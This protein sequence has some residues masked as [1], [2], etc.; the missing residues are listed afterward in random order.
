[1]GMG[2]GIWL[3]YALESVLNE[4]QRFIRWFRVKRYA[5]SHNYSFCEDDIYNKIAFSDIP[6]PQNPSESYKLSSAINVIDGQIASLKFTYFEKT[7]IVIS[8]AKIGEE[9]GRR[10]VIAIDNSANDRFESSSTFDKNLI[11]Y[12]END[13]ICFYWQ[14]ANSDRAKPIPIKKLDQW[15]ADIAGAFKAE[16]AAPF[17]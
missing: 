11:F 7:Q 6:F 16:A 12:R 4:Q 13:T 14:G 9:S 5:K 2:G 15:L 1:M 10:S 3:S 8:G 17:Q